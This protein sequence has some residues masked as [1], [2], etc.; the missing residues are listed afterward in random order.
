[1]S[2]NLMLLLQKVVNTPLMVEESKISTVLDILE[3]RIMTST[4]FEASE[5]SNN[6]RKL[7]KVENNIA[8]IPVYGS[9]VNKGLA[10]GPMSGM[11]SYKYIKNSF[12]AALLDYE[13]YEIVLDI[14]SSGGEADGNFDLVD[15]IYN[16][17]GKKR[18]TAMIDS[19]GCSAAYSIASTADEIYATRTA[20]V[21]SIGVLAV[22]V[23][24][25]EKI[26]K[27]G[28]S[29]HLVRGGDKK[30]VVTSVEPYSETM[31]SKLEENVSS[32]YKTFVDTVSRNRNISTDK[33]LDTQADT[34]TS[35]KALTVGLIDGIKTSDALMSELRDKL[36]NKTRLNMSNETNLQLELD[37]LKKEMSDKI[38]A[39]KKEG[40][41]IAL[42][43][44]TDIIQLCQ[45]AGKSDFALSCILG[46]KTSKEVR[47]LLLSDQQEKSGDQLNTA[48]AK[49]VP[50]AAPEKD[51]M[52][53]ALV[54]QY[55][56]NTK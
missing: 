18:I 35:E 54:E 53:A 51:Y 13:V 8:V 34:F 29:Y 45:L 33:I 41:T 47:E 19:V 30:A 43:E 11:T 46:G 31:Q 20:T 14:D 40:Q 52:A 23:D 15:H 6:S 1:M 10:L 39:A 24:K 9:L 37:N 49:V 55:G 48:L 50:S 36:N 22:H 17:R 25:T 16:S 3:K 26:K 27:E 7:Y 12:D 44:A 42:T 38:A 5:D 32:L 4:K 56:K 21:G 2:D 28:L